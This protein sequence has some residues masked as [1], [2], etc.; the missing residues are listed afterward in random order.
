MEF[1]IAVATSTDSWK[2][3]KRAEALGFEYAWFYDTQLLCADV[4]SVM[5]IAAHETE[6]IKLATGVTIPSNRIAPIVASAFGTLNQLAPGRVIF[7]VGTGF[8][9][10]RTMGLGAI[11]LQD[12]CDYVH[13]VYA[14]LAGETVEIEI[15][16][17]RRTI[18]LLN[19]EAGL[20]NT[21][22]PIGLHMSAMGPR[23]R[24]VC[25]QLDAGWV[26]FVS[27]A[28]GA[29]SEL[30]D[31]QSAW[32]DAGKPAEDLYATAFVLGAVLE[33]GESFDGPKAMAQA[34]PWIAV[35]FH[36]LVEAGERGSIT[37]PHPSMA[38]ALEEYKTLYE[39]YEPADARYLGL[40][41]GHL[42]SVRDDER[43]LIR[44]ELI[45]DFSFSG[46]REVICNKLE[47]LRDAGY[48]QVT[49]Q[50]VQGQEDAVEDWAAVRKHFGS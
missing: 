6:R 20:I 7:G 18:R 41:T 3:V 27:S 40:H 49:I 21:H 48:N 8:T 2:V 36:N 23:A 33:T 45:R 32:S 46:T 14:L 42:I 26:D 9:A 13:Q 28:E 43:H 50:M 31:M 34:G 12:M 30:R 17:K 25:A 44:G 5:A 4:Y 11:K 39:G 24:R 15:E 35:V 29:A 38:A 19:P 16:G 47:G 37:A 22:D 1:G 10:R